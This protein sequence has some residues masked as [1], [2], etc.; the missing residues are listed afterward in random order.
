M[1]FA[2]SYPDRPRSNARSAL[3]SR[4]S[5]EWGSNYDDRPNEQVVQWA[6]EAGGGGCVRGKDLRLDDRV[7]P[8]VLPP[9]PRRVAQREDS[10]LDDAPLLAGDVVVDHAVRRADL[11]VC[12]PSTR[13]A[14]VSLEILNTRALP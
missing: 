13:S 4:D 1:G 12:A 8:V 2:H 6:N 9:R 10:A 5:L 11:G 3:C 14:R 7:E